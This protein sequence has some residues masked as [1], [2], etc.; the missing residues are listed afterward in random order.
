MQEGFGSPSQGWK[1]QAKLRGDSELW[2]TLIHVR[3]RLSFHCQIEEDCSFRKELVY[4]L[5]FGKAPTAAMGRAGTYTATKPR[6]GKIRSKRHQCVGNDVKKNPSSTTR[7]FAGSSI[8]ASTL[9]P[10]AAPVRAYS[11]AIPTLDNSKTGFASWVHFRPFK[12][13]VTRSEYQQVG[14]QAS[15]GIL[16]FFFLCPRPNL[17]R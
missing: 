10:R 6:A 13:M 7:L 12:V 3:P 2:A 16:H 17:F 4:S 8:T 14:A 9:V 11:Q 1:V 15:A 5:S